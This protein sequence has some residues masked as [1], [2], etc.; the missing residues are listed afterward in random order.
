MD[1]VLEAVAK[2]LESVADLASNSTSFF[3]TYQPQTPDC[4]KKKSE[5]K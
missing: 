2:I 3:F 5:N 4:I 1:A